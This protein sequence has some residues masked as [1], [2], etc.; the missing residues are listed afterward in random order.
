MLKY[1]NKIAV[2]ELVKQATWLDSMKDTASKTWNGVKGAVGN[3]LNAIGNGFGLIG[4]IAREGWNQVT[5]DAKGARDARRA[6]VGNWN[7]MWDHDKQALANAGSALYNNLR[8][9]MGLTPQ[10]FLLHAARGARMQQNKPAATPSNSEIAGYQAPSG[11]DVNGEYKQTQ[12]WLKKQKQTPGLA[13]ETPAPAQTPVAAPRKQP[14]PATLASVT[15]G[16]GS[17]LPDTSFEGASTLQGVDPSTISTIMNTTYSPAFSAGGVSNQGGIGLVNSGPGE[18]SLTATQ[19]NQN[20][21]APAAA[22]VQTRGANTPARVGDRFDPSK[23]TQA[24]M[25]KYRHITGARNMNSEMDKW[26][27]Y[28]AMNGRASQATN[29][30]FRQARAARY[31]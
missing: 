23:I 28:M 15:S 3:R 31:S 27:T 18:S 21:G 12:E 24:Q 8:T 10:G 6:A 20:T 1:A 11:G 9:T 30:A 22:P 26:K 25:N 2:Q 19:V 4:N 29:A 13:K 7:R 5:G 14:S 17:G 16:G